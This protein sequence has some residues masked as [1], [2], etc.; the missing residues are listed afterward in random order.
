[1]QVISGLAL[2]LLHFFIFHILGYTN[3]S[4]ILDLSLV[5]GEGEMKISPNSTC[6][7]LTGGTNHL[8]N[9]TLMI[10]LQFGT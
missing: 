8:A 4:G 2:Q 5:L 6:K 7:A 3:T 10:C 9:L 1:M